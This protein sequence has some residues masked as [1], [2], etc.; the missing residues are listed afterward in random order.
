MAVAQ[1]GCC[2]AA[3]LEGQRC[4]GL[5]L[6]RDLGTRTRFIQEGDPEKN[7]P[8]LTLTHCWWEWKMVQLPCKAGG[9]LLRK[10]KTELPREPATPLLD[11]CPER[12]KAGIRRDICTPIFIEKL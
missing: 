5:G 4:G 11:I 9:Q 7:C 2:F 12:L 10:L 1:G 8:F 6:E 3:T